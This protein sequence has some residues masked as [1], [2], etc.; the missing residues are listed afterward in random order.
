MA[1]APDKIRIGARVSGRCGSLGAFAGEVVAASSSLITVRAA[2]GSERDVAPAWADPLVVDG[3]ATPKA[4]PIPTLHQLCPGYHKDYSKSKRVFLTAKNAK[5]TEKPKS[6]EATAAEELAR[7]KRNSEKVKNW[8][9]TKHTKVT[10]TMED[11]GMKLTKEESIAKLQAAKLVWLAKPV[12]CTD[13]PTEFVRNSPSQKRCPACQAKHDKAAKKVWAANSRARK[14]EAEKTGTDKT[15]GTDAAKTPQSAIRNPQSPA[16]PSPRET[17][18]A[19][20]NCR[21][22][23]DYYFPGVTGVGGECTKCLDLRQAQAAGVAKTSAAIE[24]NRRPST[25][26][27]KPM[28]DAPPARR[29]PLVPL[30]ALEQA[31]GQIQSLWKRIGDLEAQLARG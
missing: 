17:V 24:S 13:C 14:M 7:R 21:T 1:L 10:K 15:D 3:V 28:T 8:L 30:R 4:R 19:N 22:C 29:Y 26:L 11:A 6:L 27:D 18:V 23:G 25:A 12:E 16:S 9:T 5:V 31:H 2:D 20:E